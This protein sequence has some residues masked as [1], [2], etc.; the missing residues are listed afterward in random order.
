MTHLLRPAV[1][2]CCVT[3]MGAVHLAQQAAGIS[4]AVARLA[5]E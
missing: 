5:G 1:V 4:P 3:V 2:R